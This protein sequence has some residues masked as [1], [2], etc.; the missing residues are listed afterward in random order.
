[1]K[2]VS[3]VSRNKKIHNFPYNQSTLNAFHSVRI[4]DR[5]SKNTQE[6][7]SNAILSK[8]LK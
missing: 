4:F 3:T 8:C 5:Q 2:E 6:S 7:I 1:M